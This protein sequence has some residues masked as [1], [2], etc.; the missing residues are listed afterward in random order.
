LFLEEVLDG[1]NND[2]IPTKKE[3]KKS[4]FTNVSSLQ[5]KQKRQWMIKHGKGHFLD[6]HDE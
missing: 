5:E 6:F 1:I 4:F 2:D 3:R